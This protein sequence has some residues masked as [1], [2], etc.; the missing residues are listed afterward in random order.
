VDTIFKA[1][2]ETWTGS[3]YRDWNI[4]H[5]LPFIKC[6]LLFIQG[7]ADEYGTLNQVEKTISG[8]SGKAEKYII[9]DVGHTPHKDAAGLTFNSVKGFINKIYA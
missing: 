9:P 3:D 4:E 7:E 1:W 2:T 6:P 8:I 5:F